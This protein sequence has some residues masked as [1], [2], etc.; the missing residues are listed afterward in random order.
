ME[1]DPLLG[2][3]LSMW[4]EVKTPGLTKGASGEA[5][6]TDVIAVFG[7]EAGKLTG[8]P[9]V[10]APPPVATQSIP[11]PTKRPFTVSF[12]P[13]VVGLKLA[14]RSTNVYVTGVE[15]GSQ[16]EELGVEPGDQVLEVNSKAK[17]TNT[18]DVSMAL[19][20]SPAP[21]MTFLRCRGAW[22][23]DT[24]G[25][26]DAGDSKQPSSKGGANAVAGRQSEEHARVPAR[27]TQTALTEHASVM[28]SLQ[29]E[30]AR[31]TL[32]TILRR[33][34]TNTSTEEGQPQPRPTHS[35]KRHKH[36][37]GGVGGCG[38]GG[39][40]GKGSGSHGGDMQAPAS[41]AGDPR[42]RGGGAGGGAPV[43]HGAAGSRSL[44]PLPHERSAPPFTFNAHG[45]SPEDL[46]S[47]TAYLM[48][49]AAMQR[50]SFSCPPALTSAAGGA[51]GQYWSAHRPDQGH[52][53]YTDPTAATAAAHSMNPAYSA[54]LTAM[55]V[56]MGAGQAA[57]AAGGGRSWGGAAQRQGGS[58]GCV[59]SRSLSSNRPTTAV[60]AAVGGY[61]RSSSMPVGSWGGGVPN[62]QGPGGYSDHPRPSSSFE[63]PARAASPAVVGCSAARLSELHQ[64]LNRITAGVDA[65]T[66]ST[67]SQIFRGENWH[68]LAVHQPQGQ[69]LK[70]LETMADINGTI[71]ADHITVELS[72]GMVVL[73]EAAGSV[74]ARKLFRLIEAEVLASQADVASAAAVIRIQKWPIANWNEKVAQFEGKFRA[75]LGT[76]FSVLNQEV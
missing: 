76:S 5:E 16:A 12:G 57:A 26:A 61:S 30:H 54:A 67:F 48:Q 52:N 41:M 74:A 64:L 73:D 50:C 2:L 17:F 59:D 66:G 29:E 51:H 25:E 1:E 72:D 38:V 49:N 3:D 10:A 70:A 58:A 47:A 9:A 39:V 63:S 45:Q 46:A 40:G 42:R 65:I 18:R 7:E 14:S 22:G 8:S 44:P 55:G 11:T 27:V 32:N 60:P 31:V 28:Q 71:S 35:P 56:Q 69:L 75:S 36:L 68:H 43:L 6:W 19:L 21:T 13:G 23:G 4:Q 33:A 15:T 53:T 20:H 37:D 34:R 62:S 24:T